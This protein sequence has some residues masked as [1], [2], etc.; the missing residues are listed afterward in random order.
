MVTTGWA[1]RLC[2]EIF[3]AGANVRSTP[4]GFRVSLVSGVSGKLWPVSHSAG[5][6]EERKAV[7][8]SLHG[9]H[10]RW[11]Q[12]GLQLWAPVRPSLQPDVDFSGSSSTFVGNV[13]DE[14]RSY[15]SISTN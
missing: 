5:I 13:R 7:R 11:V 4:L 1:V 10:T 2:G 6:T 8:M 14:T 9:Q 3:S 15:S 12:M